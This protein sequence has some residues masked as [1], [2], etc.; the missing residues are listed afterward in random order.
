M[1]PDNFSNYNLNYDLTKIG[2]LSSI[3][4]YT[5]RAGPIPVFIYE[6]KPE[7]KAEDSS[8]SLFVA[9]FEFPNLGSKHFTVTGAGKTEED[10][11][12]TLELMIKDFAILLGV[13]GG[14]KID[15][16]RRSMD[17]EMESNRKYLD[18]LLEPF[19]AKL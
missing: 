10:A 4:G 3:N 9:A 7:A 14:L 15:Q 17:P 6:I 11:C 2:Q 16:P 18:M 8:A 13:I 5:L 12:Q 19:Y 1:N